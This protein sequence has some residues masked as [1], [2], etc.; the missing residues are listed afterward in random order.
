MEGEASAA[1]SAGKEAVASSYEASSI[2]SSSPATLLK[3]W[4]DYQKDLMRHYARRSLV[5]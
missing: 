3:G 5:R 4:M 2:E 1:V